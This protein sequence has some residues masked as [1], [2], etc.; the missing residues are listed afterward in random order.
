MCTQQYDPVCGV[1]GRTY[2]NACM[3]H[4]VTIAHQGECKTN[5]LKICTREYDPVCDV[6]GITHSNTCVA[7]KA[8]IAHQGE[9]TKDPLTQNILRGHAHQI[10]RYNNISDYRPNDRL[11]REE[12]SKMIT[13]T[14]SQAGVEIPY[15]GNKSCTWTDEKTIDPTLIQSVRQSCQQNLLR[16]GDDGRFMPR[17]AIEYR[18]ME[19]ILARISAANKQQAKSL[20]TFTFAEK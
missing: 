7:G 16:G 4:G 1:D 14:L 10:T 8:K 3:A 11:T 13:T 12:A 5:T 17:Q 6:N 20:P 18:Q 2:G 9:C 15:D 19:I